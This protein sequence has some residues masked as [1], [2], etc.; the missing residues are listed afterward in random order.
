VVHVGNAASDVGI[1]SAYHSRM[2][3]AAVGAAPAVRR[4]A[5][6][7]VHHFHGPGVARLAISRSLSVSM[8]MLRVFLNDDGD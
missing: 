4:L 3:Y 6:L 5:L 1:V 2:Q 8:F 7:P